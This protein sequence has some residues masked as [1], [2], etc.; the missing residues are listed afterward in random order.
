MVSGSMKPQ[1]M[2]AFQKA[3]QELR[4]ISETFKRLAQDEKI[5]DFNHFA[6]L[7]DQMVSE[8]K[9]MIEALEFV[10]DYSVDVEEKQRR[11]R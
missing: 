10:T 7:I 4:R 11:Y 3:I 8:V 5:W 1:N 9:G 2:Q 6:E